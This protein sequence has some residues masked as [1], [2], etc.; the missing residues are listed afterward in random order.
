M[1]LHSHAEVQHSWLPMSWVC[2][3]NITSFTPTIGKGK[4]KNVFPKFWFNNF[5]QWWF[6]ASKQ[7]SNPLEVLWKSF[8]LIF[9]AVSIFFLFCL[10][11]QFKKK[12]K[13]CKIYFTG[14]PKEWLALQVFHAYELLFSFNHFLLWCGNIIYLFFLSFLVGLVWLDTNTII[15]V[16]ELS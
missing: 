15:M 3:F 6:Q 5:N 12:K 14:W 2:F 16:V 8:S 7:L 10:L 9:F 1:G 11:F 4:T 13:N